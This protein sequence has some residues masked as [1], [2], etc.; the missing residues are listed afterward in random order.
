MLLYEVSKLL[1]EQGFYCRG[2]EVQYCG[3]RVGSRWHDELVLLKEH[4]GISGQDYEHA[5]KT[6]VKY[7]DSEAREK[8]T[9]AISK[10]KESYR[11][12]EQKMRDSKVSAIR[13]YFEERRGDVSI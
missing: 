13:M 5:I 12:Y 11:E 3:E 10:L 2:V 7:R 1:A 9:A 4:E 8:I 6:F